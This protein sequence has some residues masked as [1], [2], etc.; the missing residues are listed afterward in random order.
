MSDTD[1]EDGSN[2]EESDDDTDDCSESSW[3]ESDADAESLCPSLSCSE[4]AQTE[5]TDVTLQ[6]PAAKKH[7]H[8]PTEEVVIGDKLGK[9]YWKHLFRKKGS[10]FYLNDCFTFRKIE[11]NPARTIRLQVLGS[12]IQ[13]SLSHLHQILLVRFCHIQTQL[14]NQV[15]KSAT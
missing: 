9:H 5:N 13:D 10:L 4:P 3:E 14:R 7:I 1:S 12:Y 8:L 15:R 11:C 2:W 6:P